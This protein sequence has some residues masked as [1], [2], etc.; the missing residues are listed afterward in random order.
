MVKVGRIDFVNSDPVYHGLESGEVEAEVDVEL[1][2]GFPRSLNSMLERGDLDVA[3][4]SSV[5]YARHPDYG[6][7][8]GLSVSSDGEVGSILLFSREP[9]ED[10]DGSTVAV[11]STSA[12]SVVLLEILLEE[13]RDI[14]PEYDVRH[15]D[16]DSMLED[17]D[18]ALL[19]GD[20]ALTANRGDRGPSTE[21]IEVRDLGE[22]W[23]QETGERM[24]YA[25]WAYQDLDD[26]ERDAV[27]DA[28]ER[29]KEV[30]YRSLDSIAGDLSDRMDV[31][32]D[33]AERYLRMLDHDFTESHRR[34]LTKYYELARETGAID[35][36][37]EIP[38]ETTR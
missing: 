25:V 7:L 22:M 24:V 38:E 15:P 31:S 1:V 18:A 19:I 6:L 35:T 10:L 9:L 36:V 34:G 13:F 29:S 11:P 23:K 33:Y 2:D 17:A 14:H 8:P 27:A 5:E 26:G 12:T 30:G 20:H 28:L 37:P 21:D 32:L 16:V 3:P 4:I